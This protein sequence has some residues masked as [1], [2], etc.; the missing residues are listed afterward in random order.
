MDPE[1]EFFKPPSSRDILRAVVRSLKPDDEDLTGRTA[2][3]YYEGRHVKEETEDRIILALADTLVDTGFLPD[4]HPVSETGVSNHDLLTSVI[5][6]HLR[7][8]DNLVG[9]QKGFAAPVRSGAVLSLAYL[10]LAVVDLAFRTAA[11]CWLAGSALPDEQPPLWA[12][13]D[14]KGRYLRV[15]MGRIDS[16]RLSLKGRNGVCQGRWESVP[17]GRSKTVPLN[18]TA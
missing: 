18:A 17:V 7:R 11:I 10:R 15:L 14:G 9:G 4:A 5:K 6:W 12:R 2:R 3:H 16:R 8:W 13:K 1:T